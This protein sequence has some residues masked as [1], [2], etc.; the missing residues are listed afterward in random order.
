M[1]SYEGTFFNICTSIKFSE[2]TDT[3]NN[4]VGHILTYYV[5]N[6]LFFILSGLNCAF[7]QQ[8]KNEIIVCALNM[9]HKDRTASKAVI[10]QETQKS[11]FFYFSCDLARD[12]CQ[13]KAYPLSFIGGSS[14][15]CNRNLSPCR[16]CDSLQYNALITL[17]LR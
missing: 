14:L 15:I 11:I 2:V 13:F 3:G 7:T 6:L 10:Y 17:E 12:Q 4:N 16:Q 9:L 5:L 8:G 1:S